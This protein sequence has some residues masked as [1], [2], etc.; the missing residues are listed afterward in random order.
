M[1][2][3]TWSVWL[4]WLHVILYDLIVRLI[5]YHLKTGEYSYWLTWSLVIQDFC[6]MWVKIII[7]GW[8]LIYINCN[9]QHLP[10]NYVIVYYSQIKT[11]ILEN[12]CLWKHYT[13]TLDVSLNLCNRHS[14]RHVKFGHHYQC[15]FW[16]PLPV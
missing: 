13:V 12:L 10:G 4:P 15:K 2:L 16:S 14:Q 8:L 9:N 11:E 3:C 6:F 5:S 1:N 7:S